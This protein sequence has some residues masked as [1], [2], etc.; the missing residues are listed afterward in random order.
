LQ[1]ELGNQGSMIK[2]ISFITVFLTISFLS[3]LAQNND[4]EKIKS[5]L[6]EVTMHFSENRITESPIHLNQRFTDGRFTDL[7]YDNNSAARWHWGIHWQRLTTLAVAYNLE[8]SGLYRSASLKNNLIAGVD[9]WIEYGTRPYNGWWELIGVPYEMGKVFILMENELGS[10]RLQKLLPQMNLAVTPDF[11]D[12]GGRKATGQNLL[13]EAFNHVYA[14]ALAGDEAGLNR[15][16]TAAANEFIITTDEGIQP[17]F[18]FHQHG[19]L[20]Y[21][22]GYGKDFSLSAA[23]IL[24]TAYDT[25]FSLPDKKTDIISAFLLEGQRWC[26]YRN[27]LEYTAMGREISRTF[28]KSKVIAMAAELLSRIDVNR[29]DELK[30]YANHLYKSSE[31]EFSGFNSNLVTGNRYF[32]RIDFM[33]QQGENYMMTIKAVSKGLKSTETGNL[34]NLKGY[35]L[36]RG[37]QFI[38][39]RGNEYEGIFPLWNWEKLPGSLCEQTGKPLPVYEWSKGAEG[40]TEFV[41]GVSN[42]KTGCFT[43]EFDKDSISAHRSWFFFENEMAMLVADLEFNRPNPVFQ[44]VNQVFAKG[45]VYVNAKKLKTDEMKSTRIKSVWHDSVAYHFDVQPFS[46]MVQSKF[47]R[48]AWYEI[49]R[50][51]SD[52]VIEEKLFTI[53]IDAGKSLKNGAFACVIAPNV[54]A[55]SKSQLDILKN[56]TEQQVVY[57]KNARTLQFAAYAPCEIELPWS[58]MKLNLT[59]AGVGVIQQQGSELELV[60]QALEAEAVSL[61]AKMQKDGFISF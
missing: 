52:K 34:E 60:F 1:V 6:H 41:L 2:R 59:Q 32:P 43:Y 10:E 35:H 48:G 26:S 36:S 55:N 21:A 46:V 33:V 47:H 20:S 45:D 14:S 40:N 25:K 23:Q 18:S 15:A 57:N 9:Y 24:Y 27:M 19:A 61:S 17:D 50:A 56:T 11:Y 3:L 12:Y 37:T 51:E 7:D 28:N 31:D 49:N 8:E 22:F 54:G 29:K 13:W 53:G 38:V 39:R 44:S 58:K 42:G 4:I 30:A 16:F 5:K